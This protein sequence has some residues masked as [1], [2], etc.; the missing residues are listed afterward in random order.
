MKEPTTIKVSKKEIDNLLE[1]VEALMSA[2]DF[3]KIKSVFLM[4]EQ[5]GFAYKEKSNKVSE[6]LKMFFGSTSEKQK[7]KPSKKNKKK[8]GKNKGKNPVTDYKSAEHIDVPHETLKSGDICLKCEKGK[9][10]SYIP[11]RILRITGSTPIQ[12]VIYH[13]EKFRCNLCGKIFEAELPE[14]AAAEKYDEKASA[15]IALLRYGTGVP[16]FR[17]EGLQKMLGIPLPDSTQWDVVNTM[18]DKIFPAYQELCRIASYGDIF[19][20]DDTTVKI[21]SLMKE[22]EIANPKRKGMFTTGIISKHDD[23]KIALFLSGRKHAGEN[24]ADILKLRPKTRGAPIQMSDA[25]SRNIPASYA[26]INAFCMSH[27]RRGFV[28]VEDQFPDEVEYVVGKIGVIYKNDKTAGKEK[29]SPE[30]RLAF[31]QEKSG[32]VMNEVYDWIDKKLDKDVEPNSGLGKAM[33]YMVKH[34]KEL[35]TF[36]RVA[37]TPLDNNECE[38]A[39]KKAIIQRKNSLFYKTEHGAYIGSLF[40]SL[41]HTCSLNNINPFDYFVELQENVIQVKSDPENWMP[42]NYKENVISQG[43]L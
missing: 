18:A 35:T 2:D 16:F 39:L 20:N 17:L 21:L 12:A 37:G 29:M 6:L 27:G 11:G 40:I 30:E 41:I 38:R 33:R 4:I 22:N 31:H 23:I 43:N 15:L 32:P 14:N 9:I 7:R 3:E 10:Y 5:L 1:K 36:L 34:K 26:L 13:T 24:L 25:A 28:K 42:W 8:K 19:Y